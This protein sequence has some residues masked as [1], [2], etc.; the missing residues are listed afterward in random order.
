MFQD[1][2]IIGATGKVGSTLVRQILE[3]RDTDTSLHANPTRIVGVASRDNFVY[4]PRGLSPSQAY[5]FASRNFGER[6]LCYNDCGFSPIRKEKPK[7]INTVQK[8]LYW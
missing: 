2:F 3:K 7:R 8:E 4:S 1:V 6:F 5:S